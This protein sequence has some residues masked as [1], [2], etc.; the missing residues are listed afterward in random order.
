MSPLTPTT[1]IR[2]EGS[3]STGTFSVFI[4]VSSSSQT[5]TC[6]IVDTQEMSVE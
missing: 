1:H 2:L 3:M 4:T 6:H 5:H